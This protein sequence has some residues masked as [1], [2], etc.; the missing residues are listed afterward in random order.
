VEG[1]SGLRL[2]PD[3]KTASLG[4]GLSSDSCSDVFSPVSGHLAELRVS[5]MG[6]ETTDLDDSDTIWRLGGEWRQYVTL[7]P[8]VVWAGRLAGGDSKG[9]SS[10][11]F[12]YAL[13]GSR[14]TTRS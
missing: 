1:D 12:R 5:W 10:Y 9:D 3:V 2:F 13:W 4:A 8:R 6:S 7:S 11:R 14:E